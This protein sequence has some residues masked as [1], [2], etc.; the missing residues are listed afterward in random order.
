MTVFA[1]CVMNFFTASRS[2]PSASRSSWIFEMTL[3]TWLRSSSAST[4]LR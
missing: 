3:P 4:T 2:E 1:G